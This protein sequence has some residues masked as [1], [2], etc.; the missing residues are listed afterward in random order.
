MNFSRMMKKGFCRIHAI[1]LCSVLITAMLPL[2]IPTFSSEAQAAETSYWATPYLQDMVNKGIMTGN[3]NGNLN[4][5]DQITRAEFTTMI[6]RALGFTKSGEISFKDVEPHAWYYSSINTGAAEG[7]FKGVGNNL[8][9]PDSSI[10]REAAVTMLGRALKIQTNSRLSNN[11]A[12][13]QDISYWS[14]DYVNA[15]V[16]KGILSGYNDGR[17]IPKSQISRAEVA[18]ILSSLVG[19][20]VDEKRQHRLDYVTGNVTISASGGGLKNTVINGDLYITDGIGNGYVLLDNVTV[21]GQVIISGAGESNS[22][23]CSVILRNCD[24]NEMIVD[25]PNTKKL[26]ISTQGKTIIGNTLIKSKA[27]IENNNESGTPFANLTIDAAPNDVV[28]LVGGFSNVILKGKPNTLNLQK[29]YIS[30]LTVD[31]DAAGSKVFL[32][33]GTDVS[34]LFLDT[35]AEVTGKGNIGEAVINAPGTSIE[36]LPDKIT[37]RPGVTAKIKGQD[38]TAADGT[39]STVRPEILPGYPK[40]SDEDLTSAKASFKSNKAGKLYWA[41]IPQ[42]FAEPSAAQLI[43]PKLNGSVVASGNQNISGATETTIAITG[44]KQGTEYTIY[45]ILVDNRDAQSSIRYADFST[46]DNTAPVFTYTYAEAKTSKNDATGEYS[47]YLDASA[48]VSKNATVYYMLLKAGSTAPIASDLVNQRMSAVSKGSV[49]FSKNVMDTIAIKNL[50]ESASYDLYLLAVDE[51]SRQSPIVKK[52]VKMSDTTPPELTSLIDNKSSNSITFRYVPTED[53]AKVY[54]AIYYTT[55]STVAEIEKETR[56]SKEGLLWYETN[57]GLIIKGTGAIQSTGAS[58]NLKATAGQ[59]STFTVS[60]L[61]KQRYY[62]MYMVLEDAAGNQSVVYTMESSTIDTDAPTEMLQFSSTDGKNLYVG[63]PAS[64]TAVSIVFS[65][66][67]LGNNG[68][69]SKYLNAADM[70]DLSAWIKLYEGDENAIRDSSKLL[71]INWSMVKRTVTPATNE[72][73][74]R[75]VLTFTVSNGNNTA[76]TLNSGKQYTFLFTY[77]P[78]ANIYITDLSG[79][80]MKKIVTNSAEGGNFTSVTDTFKCVEPS[81][82]ITAPAGVSSV[83]TDANGKTHNLDLTY[84]VTPTDSNKATDSDVKYDFYIASDKPSIVNIFRQTKDAG[85][86]E[87]IAKDVTLEPS[88]NMSLEESVSVMRASKGAPVSSLDYS[89]QTFRTMAEGYD[90]GSI[91]IGLE[92]TQ[93]NYN[94]ERKTWNGSMTAR[95]SC[96]TGLADNLYRKANS[97]NNAAS[98]VTSVGSADDKVAFTDEVEPVLTFDNIK[99]GA[100]TMDVQVT[101]DKDVTLYWVAVQ[102]ELNPSLRKTTNQ[103]FNY[104][105]AQSDKTNVYNYSGTPLQV[106]ESPKIVQITGLQPKT[107]YTVYF[108]AKSKSSDKF[109][110]YDLKDSASCK[111]THGNNQFVKGQTTALIAPVFQIVTTSGGTNFYVEAVDSES[112]GKQ[113]TFRMLTDLPANVYWTVVTADNHSRYSAVVAESPNEIASPTSKSTNGGMT[114]LEASGKNLS[115]QA[116]N[117]AGLYETKV[118]VTGLTQDT[119]YYFF[120]LATNVV[121]NSI[122][123][124]STYPQYINYGSFILPDKTAPKLTDIALVWTNKNGGNGTL[125]GAVDVQVNFD[126]ALYYKT[127]TDNISKKLTSS[128]ITNPQIW[129]IMPEK[130]SARNLMGGTTELN[131]SF[132]V[133]PLLGRGGITGLNIKLTGVDSNYNRSVYVRTNGFYFCNSYG[134]SAGYLRLDFNVSGSGES[135]TLNCTARLMPSDGVAS[136][137][138]TQSVS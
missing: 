120:A 95:L 45:G 137:T 108:V 123:N 46:V 104:I 27:F 76:L 4:P 68:G 69:T 12:D 67:V 44:L 36:Q 28:D 1:L 121:D 114:M 119:D 91:V 102:G 99:T 58:S 70:T 29:G 103:V 80:A 90:S 85:S 79:N 111:D 15:I 38:M 82:S 126:K 135:A 47:Y 96:V 124:T 78:A 51:N 25:T 57:Q 19:N 26:S 98:N 77:N 14:R 37:I 59:E 65:E 128:I 122:Y 3:E 43:N 6:N 118:T 81:V 34:K 97:P 89:S 116:P 138:V 100:T 5:S 53:C 84:R 48:T 62:K 133:K 16:D 64:P 105:Q 41:V 87:L 10:T 71:P 17:F 66:T 56:F 127:D 49:K 110:V 83:Y 73:P 54:W 55:S 112:D 109:T 9:A 35:A 63:T 20:I 107:E 30:N 131:R 40:I 86:W 130:M 134:T 39:E 13:A 106:I 117:P 93:Y 8:A 101:C 61:G 129:N 136:S 7:Y 88:A 60:N 42:G 50:Q 132:T 52:T 92:V 94:A 31:E 115:S 21:L 33:A 22:G 74:E 24:I 23:A 113:M 11:F 75:T 72:A 32:A 18:K 125:T 2:S